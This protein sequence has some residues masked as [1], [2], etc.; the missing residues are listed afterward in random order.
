VLLL[1]FMIFRSKWIAVFLL[2][3]VFTALNA[4]E[5][6]TVPAGWL[7]AAVLGFCIAYC[8]SAFGLLFAVVCFAVVDMLQQPM[9]SDP[10]L[11]YFPNGMVILGIVAM[12]AIYGYQT[13]VGNGRS[14]RR[15]SG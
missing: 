9:T 15:M 11:F 7:V 13:S 6:N 2:G 5:F 1:L 3:G 10:S 4:L 12:I 14:I 8:F